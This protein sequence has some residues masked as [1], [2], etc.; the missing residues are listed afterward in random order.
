MRECDISKRDLCLLL[1]SSRMMHI[2]YSCLFMIYVYWCISM[3][4]VIFVILEVGKVLFTSLHAWGSIPIKPHVNI[5]TKWHF[6]AVWW[7]LCP[8]SDILVFS[9]CGFCDGAF[10]PQPCHWKM[11]PGTPSSGDLIEPKKMLNLFLLSFEKCS[12]DGIIH[13]SRFC[14]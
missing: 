11:L 4:Y 9:W 13:C 6:C 14:W 3:I 7:S 1:V 8:S 5:H 10:S 12:L 2:Q